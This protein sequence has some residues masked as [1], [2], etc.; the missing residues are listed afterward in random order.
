[1]V[2]RLAGELRE[3]AQR[4]SVTFSLDAAIDPP[5][6]I[7]DERRCGQVMAGLFGYAVRGAKR[8]SQVA[9]RVMRHGRVVLVDVRSNG[10]VSPADPL[11]LFAERRD[12]A[13][14]VPKPYR[15]P[16]LGLPFVA[17]VV[18]ALGGGVTAAADGDGLV[19]GLTFPT[20]PGPD[21]VAKSTS[22]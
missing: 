4:R 22:A 16:G 21:D 10:V 3:V 6:V 5:Q 18:T 2:S 20:G 7:A 14:G 15:G 19:L 9:G 12:R 11:S 1:M 8:G 17:R 13:P